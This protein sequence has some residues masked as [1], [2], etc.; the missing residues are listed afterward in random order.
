MNQRPL[1]LRA[2]LQ[3]ILIVISLCGCGVWLLGFGWMQVSAERRLAKMSAE[4][5]GRVIGH[6]TRPL[7]KGGRSSTLLIEY[8]PPNLPPITK[9]F[10]VDAADYRSGVATGKAKVTYLPADPQVSRV[11]HFAVFPFQILVGF[12][13]LMIVA[14]LFCLVHALIRARS[15]TSSGSVPGAE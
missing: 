12:G 11:T 15:R 9:E 2:F 1:N 8:M 10:D 3:V 5:E 6:S 4:V 13:G 14:G 7:S